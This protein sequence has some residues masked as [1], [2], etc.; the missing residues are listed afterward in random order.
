[1]EAPQPWALVFF[2]PHLSLSYFI[3]H[4]PALFEQS[5]GLPS[6]SKY[7]KVKRECAHKRERESL[8]TTA[9]MCVCL[10]MSMHAH[11][12]MY[13]KDCK[14][15]ILSMISQ[16]LNY[17]LN[18]YSVTWAC[19]FLCQKCGGYT[20]SIGVLFSCDLTSSL[21]LKKILLLASFRVIN[22]WYRC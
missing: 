7:A 18:A 15:E 19:L 10:H 4:M 12:C 6:V 1:M 8:C 3:I 14:R 20:R 16:A 22:K 9:C 21:S 13:D 5:P 17:S 2:S 11:A